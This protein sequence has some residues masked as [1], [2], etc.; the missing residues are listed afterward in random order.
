MQHTLSQ[1]TPGTWAT[2]ASN[3]VQ[4]VAVGAN[5]AA[6]YLTFGLDF[7]SNLAGQLGQWAVARVS[8]EIGWVTNPDHTGSTRGGG[9]EKITQHEKGTDVVVYQ[10]TYGVNDYQMDQWIQKADKGTMYVDRNGSVHWTMTDGDTTNVFQTIP[11]SSRPVFY[12]N[13]GNEGYQVS[14]NQT[15]IK[16]GQATS[17]TI[18]QTKRKRRKKKKK[19]IHMMPLSMWSPLGN[20]PC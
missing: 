13:T 6:G 4:P 18:T 20:R 7:V 9:S 17:R 11:G 5:A 8:H 3:Q 19:G 15:A 10:E 14:V 2:Y 1:S 12:P 16:H